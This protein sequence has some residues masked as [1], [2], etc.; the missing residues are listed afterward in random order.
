MGGGVK[1]QLF[2]SIARGDASLDSDL[3][4][5]ILYLN[6]HALNK[7]MILMEHAAG[8]FPIDIVAAELLAPDTVDR[9]K[10]LGRGMRHHHR[11]RLRPAES[12]P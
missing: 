11:P 6:G 2:G 1:L 12:W 7:A 8:N 4:V 3:D 5:L 9:G 10:P